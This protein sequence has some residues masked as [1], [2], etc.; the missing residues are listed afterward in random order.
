MQEKSN[1]IGH[2]RHSSVGSE[3]PNSRSQHVASLVQKWRKVVGLKSP[4]SQVRVAW[5]AACTLA[6]HVKQ[7]LVVGADID[8]EVRRLSGKFE[9][10]AEVENGYIAL[11]ASR[12]SYPFRFPGGKLG[13]PLDGYDRQANYRECKKKPDRFFHGE[14]HR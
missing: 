8:D 11:R 14:E 6:I 9:G 4:V 2:L 7:E 1:A 5:S 3:I 12:G 13:I 10:L